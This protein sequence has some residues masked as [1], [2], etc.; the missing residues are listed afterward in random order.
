M[1][2]VGLAIIA[3]AG[4]LSVASWGLTF[5]YAGA[6]VALGWRAYVVFMPLAGLLA[7][8]LIYFQGDTEKTLEDLVNEYLKDGPPLQDI[9]NRVWRFLK[10]I[11]RFLKKVLKKILLYLFKVRIIAIIV[12]T[13]FFCPYFTPLAVNLCVKGHKRVYFWAIIL[14]MLGTA[15][16]IFIYRGGWELVKSIWEI[17]LLLTI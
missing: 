2:K 6:I 8:I 5:I 17:K 11:A 10:A 4:A 15:L 1:K 12:S 7:G 14:N 16:W 3:V 13:I 9:K